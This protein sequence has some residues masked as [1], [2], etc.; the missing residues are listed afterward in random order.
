MVLLQAL[1]AVVAAVDRG[2]RGDEGA[3]AG[4]RR[5]AGDARGDGRGANRRVVVAL[6]LAV[7]RVEHDVDLAVLDHV[8]DVR[9]ALVDL[10]DALD[11]DAVVLER[12][13]GA[14]GREQLVA[15]VGELGCRDL[16]P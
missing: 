6:H 16:F 11:L 15:E 5:D 1:H 7:G 2:E 3:D 9:A 8:D 14:V 12:A 13:V 4:A 10:V